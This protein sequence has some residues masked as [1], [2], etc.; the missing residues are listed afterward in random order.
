M[1]RI[2]PDLLFTPGVRRV[3]TA[4][5]AGGAISRLVGGC[6]RD[7]L[8]GMPIGD[9]DLA[10]DV[11]PWH[12]TQLLEG[13]GIRTKL[14]GFEYGSILA[15][16]PEGGVVE[17]TSLR[18]D[19]ESDGR[20]P[21]VRF[22]TDW[23]EDARRRDFTMNALYAGEEGQVMDP[24]GE[25]LDD[26]LARRVRFVG[27]PALR[28]REDN[29]RILRFFRFQAWIGSGPM[30][31]EG[32][33]ACRNAA[34]GIR[35]LSGERVRNEM[36]RLLAAPN[37]A[38]AV[39]G[40]ERAGVLQVALPG[41]CSRG[42]CSLIS[43]EREHGIVPEWMRRWLLLVARVPG[44]PLG[45]AWPLSRREQR[46]LR[47]RLAAWR[48]KVSP[49]E[50]GYRWGEQAARDVMLVRAA[51]GEGPV[52]GT[53]LADAG[54]ATRARL[55]VSASDLIRAGVPKGPETG[56]ALRRAE[57]YWCRRRMRPGKEKLLEVALS[58]GP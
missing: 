4:L 44:D 14:I 39:D 49:T 51:L 25:G 28:I 50:Y 47:D 12:S 45:D 30:D 34:E 35:L 53:D 31:G 21:R 55:P 17:V 20:R 36:R 6:V 24:L 43:L 29:L 26:L 9:R 18:R 13:H 40:A 52:S 19:V 57:Q 46:Q 33:R 5:G 37:P 58:K 54:A 11:P 56:Q 23:T 15:L 38:D 27:D 7:A 16:P 10:V 1:S 48:A 32:L 22:G 2:D 3:M 8:L 42:L 41:S